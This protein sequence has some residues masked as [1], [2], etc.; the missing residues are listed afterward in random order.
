MAL[1]RNITMAEKEIRDYAQRQM[2]RVEMRENI[3]FSGEQKEQILEYAA[4]IGE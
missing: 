3:S 2:E 4:M 1:S